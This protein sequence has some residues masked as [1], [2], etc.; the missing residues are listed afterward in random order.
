MPD[1]IPVA[2]QIFHLILVKILQ[3]RYCYYSHFY[4]EEVEA[5][6]LSHFPEVTQL[7]SGRG[8]ICNQRVRFQGPYS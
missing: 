2:L 1:T 5:P 7:M 8:R 3:S 6:K 4:N